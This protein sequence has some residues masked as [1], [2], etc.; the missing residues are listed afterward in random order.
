MDS[1]AEKTY[2]TTSV[3]NFLVK[4]LSICLKL[5]LKKFGSKNDWH[6][7][8]TLIAEIRLQN[9]GFYLVSPNFGFIKFG[10][11]KSQPLKTKFLAW[12]RIGYRRPKL[13]LSSRTIW[14]SIEGCPN[15]LVGRI[16]TF[17]N[18]GF[19]KFLDQLVLSQPFDRFIRPEVVGGTICAPFCDAEKFGEFV[20]ATQN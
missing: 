8:S 9:L 14:I 19:Q 20:G 11:I 18:F 15:V 4:K 6:G 5:G 3:I 12:S 16:R 1:L 17:E 2:P 7:F 10:L 13:S